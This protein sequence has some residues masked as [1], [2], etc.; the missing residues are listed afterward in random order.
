MRFLQAHRRSRSAHAERGNRYYPTPRLLP[1][2]GVEDAPTRYE[3]QTLRSG[4]P[5]SDPYEVWRAE[6]DAERE[7]T[8]VE[9][10]RWVYRQRGTVAAPSSKEAAAAEA[11]RWVNRYRGVGSAPT[12]R[13]TAPGLG[14]D[15]RSGRREVPVDLV[16]AQGG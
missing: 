16:G 7:R 10:V 12:G 14:A 9:A 11:A 6:R 13:A 4:A 15:E 8:R 1:R 5:A 2:D 3:P